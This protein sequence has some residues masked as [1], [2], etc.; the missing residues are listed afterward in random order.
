MEITYKIDSKPTVAQVA[1]LY[2][3]A[4]L[5]RPTDDPERMQKMLDNTN[6]LVTAW[7]GER[8]V[9]LSRTIT[10][11]VWCAYLADLAI[12]PGYQR[13][14]IGKQLIQLTKERVGEQSMLLLL[15]APNAKEYYPKIG[16]EKEDR[17]FIIHREK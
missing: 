14:G 7:D 16:F 8:L 3:S 17:A 12:S 6:L 4:P 1:E 13:L 10:D 2:N 5:R 9:G 11:W 15:S